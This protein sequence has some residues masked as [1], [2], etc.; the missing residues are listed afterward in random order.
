LLEPLARGLGHR[1]LRV[2]RA[3]LVGEAAARL[4]ALPHV[5]LVD[6]APIEHLLAGASVLVVPSQWEEPFGRVA[7]EGLAAGV[8]T[9]ASAVGGPAGLVPAEQLVRPPDE[10]AAWLAALASLEDHAAWEAARERGLSAA[11]AVLALD[12]PERLERLLVAVAAGRL[13][14]RTPRRAPVRTR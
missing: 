10:P 5:E 2:T 6:P 11:R 8:P 1:T 3:G 13:R 14:A 7:F 4:A 12:A 9:L